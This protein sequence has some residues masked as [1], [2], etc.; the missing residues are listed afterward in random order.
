MTRER[1]AEI[2]KEYGFTTNQIDLLWNSRPGDDLDEAKL[3]KTA[4]YIAPIK[5]TLV[6]AQ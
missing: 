6:Q 5:D 4:E 3:R 1:F 2:L